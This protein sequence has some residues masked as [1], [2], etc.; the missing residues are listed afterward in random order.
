MI[1]HISAYQ[2]PAVI[3]SGGFVKA[4][5]IPMNLDKKDLTV[6]GE[7]IKG[8]NTNSCGTLYMLLPASCREA[9]QS[10]ELHT[11]EDT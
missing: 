9:R 1:G 10:H 7:R 2:H 3:G 11:D 5:K 4:K 6:E 8:T